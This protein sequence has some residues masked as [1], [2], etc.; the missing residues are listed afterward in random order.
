MS[1]LPFII[2][3]YYHLFIIISGCLE[4]R[5][6]ISDLSIPTFAK[7]LIALL[8]LWLVIRSTLRVATDRVEQVSAS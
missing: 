2:T 6:Y 7:E 1:L 4:R 3:I 8:Y 5:K